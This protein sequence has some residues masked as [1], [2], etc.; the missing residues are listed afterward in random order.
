M[1]KSKLNQYIKVQYIQIEQKDLEE[2][3]LFRN[4]PENPDD[5]EECEA[6]R[7]TIENIRKGWKV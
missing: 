2:T 5:K 3:T 4:R 6:M 1:L 7:Q